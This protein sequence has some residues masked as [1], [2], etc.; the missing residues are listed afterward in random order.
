MDNVLKYEQIVQMVAKA[1]C[2]T[3]PQ[4][5]D[6]VIQEIY[7]ALLEAEDGHTER[8]YKTVAKNAAKR[9][10]KK[11]SRF[12][13]KHVLAGLATGQDAEDDYSEESNP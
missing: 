10:F 12:Y 7:I 11:E 8:Y 5:L 9:F 3:R 2:V 6:D 1:E 13:D 4:D